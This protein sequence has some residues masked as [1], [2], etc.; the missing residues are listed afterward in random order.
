MKDFLHS[1]SL[2]A[3]MTQ[4]A[5]SVVAPLTGCILLSVWLKDRF[6]LGGWVVAVGVVLGLLGAVGGL[7]TSIRLMD[8]QGAAA[9]KQSSDRSDCFN[10]H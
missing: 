5:L 4:F 9:Q 1:A 8:R 10:R 7:I 6:A 2:L 3:W